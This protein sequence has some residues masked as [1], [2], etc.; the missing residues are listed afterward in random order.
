MDIFHTMPDEEIAEKRQRRR[1]DSHKKARQREAREGLRKRYDPG[2][3]VILE[4]VH[5]DRE[6]RKEPIIWLLDQR[7]GFWKNPRTLDDGTELGPWQA[8]VPATELQKADSNPE[9]WKCV[10]D[11]RDTEAEPDTEPDNS[12]DDKPVTGGITEVTETTT[13]DTEPDTD[14][15]AETEPVGIPDQD[16]AQQVDPQVEFDI[17]SDK[18]LTKSGNVRKNASKEDVDRFHELA[19]E[20]GG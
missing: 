19:R 6:M 10:Y 4:Y 15:E 11:P 20:L 9:A 8:R 1:R 7:Y 2:I 5:P 14:T 17:L 16:F 18:V 13:E 12:L 3:M